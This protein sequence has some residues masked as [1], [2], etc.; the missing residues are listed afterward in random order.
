MTAEQFDVAC[1]AFCRRRPFRAFL[2][3]FTSGAQVLIGHPEAV[4]DQTDMLYMTRGPDASY[5]VFAAD[6]VSRLLDVP[7]HTSTG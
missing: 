2:I 6:T 3:E 4:R 1:R 5:V 7:Q